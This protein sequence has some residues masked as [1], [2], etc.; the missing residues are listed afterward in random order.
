MNDSNGGMK[1]ILNSYKDKDK[2]ILLI[3]QQ[4]FHYTASIVKV[5]DD[6]VLFLDK[7]KNEILLKFEQIKQ[8]GGGTF[9]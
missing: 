9:N 2:N 7:F 3:T 4:D 8:V 1:K 6:S 5:Y